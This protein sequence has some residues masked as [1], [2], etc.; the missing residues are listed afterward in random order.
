MVMPEESGSG[1]GATTP[2]R[3]APKWTGR[4][5]PHTHTKHS[6]FT[7]LFN[8][9]FP[10]SIARPAEVVDQ[11]V[12]KGLD[13]VCVTDHDTISGSLE[14]VK[15]AK[16]N[17]VD[18][19]VIPGEEVTSQDG[20]ILGWFVQEHIPPGLSAEETIDKIHDQGGLAVAP[21][22]FSYHC[23]SLNKKVRNLKLDGI[24]VL[25]AGHRDGYINRLAEAN[26]GERARTGG[27]DAHTSRVVGTAF[28]R[29]NGRSKDEFYKAVKL[30]QTKPGGTTTTLRQYISW[31][32]EVAQHVTRDLIRPTMYISESDPLHRMHQMRRRNKVLA[33]VGCLGYMN[34]PIPIFGGAIAEAVLKRKG[35]EKWEEYTKS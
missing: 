29:F 30:R 24:E 21:H 31:S 23:P 28:T 34:S 14:A 33:V 9:P 1:K 22:P 11:A 17:R 20:E 26:A 7:R 25:N 4:A 15:Y 8:I 12:K 13:V 10:E 2:E 32:F 3:G 18:I 27:S 6:G 5:D 16:E 19:D 35:R